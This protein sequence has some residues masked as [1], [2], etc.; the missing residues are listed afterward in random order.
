M[1][2]TLEASFYFAK[3]KM[4]YSSSNAWYDAKIFYEKSKICYIIKEVIVGN[5]MYGEYAYERKERLS[6]TI[7]GI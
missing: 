4:D 2:E 6:I 1:G 5:I 7:G 3:T